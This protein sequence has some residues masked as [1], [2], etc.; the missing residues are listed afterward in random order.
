[1]GMNNF[2]LLLVSRL[3]VILVSLLARGWTNDNL[4]HQVSGDFA[5][6]AMD[7]ARWLL[8]YLGEN[9]HLCYIAQTKLNGHGSILA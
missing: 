9:F 5:L 6:W 4:A 1:M 2:E 8:G 3:I 7:W